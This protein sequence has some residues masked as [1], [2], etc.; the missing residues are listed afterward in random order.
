[1]KP[2]LEF[3]KNWVERGKQMEGL[4]PQVIHYQSERHA[5]EQKGLH[6]HSL[7]RKEAVLTLDVLCSGTCII[8]RTFQPYDQ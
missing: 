5:V 4:S 7:W 3:A 1:M 6:Y 8:S 2:K